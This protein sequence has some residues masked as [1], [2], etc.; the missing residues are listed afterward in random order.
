MR[1]LRGG[2]LLKQ[3]ERASVDGVR[4]VRG[5]NLL[6]IGWGLVVDFVH[7]LLGGHFPSCNVGNFVHKLRGGPVP[8]NRRAD[9]LCE[10]SRWH[11]RG[12]HRDPV[13][14]AVRGLLGGHLS[15]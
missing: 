4:G 13:P 5:G 12:D 15:S 11:L 6:G 1:E 9:E 3:H 10:L 2:L 14:V 7:E 8:V